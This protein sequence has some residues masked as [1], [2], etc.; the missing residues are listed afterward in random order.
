MT[1]V[2]V[3]HSRSR[4]PSHVASVSSATAVRAPLAIMTAIILDIAK[5]GAPDAVLSLGR[6]QELRRRFGYEYRVEHHHE[7]SG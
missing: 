3:D 7:E 4:A 5:L 6:L 2:V 1:N